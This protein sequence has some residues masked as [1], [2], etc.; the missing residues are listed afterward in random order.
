M[1]NDVAGRNV[2]HGVSKPCA[3][4]EPAL[5][6]EPVP[7]HA[8]FICIPYSCINLNI[9]YILIVHKS[10]KHVLIYHIATLHMHTMT[11]D[12]TTAIIQCLIRNITRTRILTLMRIWCACKCSHSFSRCGTRTQ[13]NPQSGVHKII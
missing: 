8:M 2:L 10:C 7:H 6:C 5:I 13:G 1:L 3:H 12:Y 11:R 9:L 4:V